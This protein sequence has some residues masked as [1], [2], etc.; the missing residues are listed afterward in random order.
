MIKDEL[1]GGDPGARGDGRRDA[2]GGDRRVCRADRAPTGRPRSHDE[3]AL[4]H[5]RDHQR[6]MVL[7]SMGI[8]VPQFAIAAVRTGRSAS[9]PFSSP[10]LPCSCDRDSR[11]RPRPRGNRRNPHAAAWTNVPEPTEDLSGSIAIAIAETLSPFGGRAHV[12]DSEVVGRTHTTRYPAPSS[13]DRHEARQGRRASFTARAQ[14]PTSSRGVPRSRQRRPTANVRATGVFRRPRLACALRQEQYAATAIVAAPNTRQRT[15]S[16]AHRVPSFPMCDA[17][18][19]QL[20]RTAAD[21]KTE[22]LRCGEP[23]ARPGLTE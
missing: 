23:S 11:W 20:A 9:L 19:P 10:V 13:T 14:Q 4:K 6:E 17:R 3:R 5:E 16:C 15:R 12:D 1:E 7:G 21:D 8:S 18:G 2:A 22:Q